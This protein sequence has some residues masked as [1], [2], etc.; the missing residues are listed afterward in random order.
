MICLKHL[1][2]NVSENNTNRMVVCMDL[3]QA[4]NTPKLSTNIAFYK[5]KLSTYN[6]CIHDYTTNTGHMF[7]WDQ[8]TAKQG[9]AEIISC[10]DKSVKFYVPYDITKLIFFSDNCPG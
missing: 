7:V 3:Q 10:I 5:R 6:F 8:V 2:Q 1:S 4:L 9:A